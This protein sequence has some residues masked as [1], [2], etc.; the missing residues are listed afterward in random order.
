[1]GTSV[2]KA[3]ELSTAG[4]RSPVQSL[5]QALRG[6][7]PPYTLSPAGPCDTL[8]T[9]HLQAASLANMTMVSPA[10]IRFAGVT[11]PDRKMPLSN[12]HKV[13]YVQ[14]PKSA[15]TRAQKPTGAAECLG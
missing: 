12:S 3:K 8:V 1:M 6:P 9:S 5:P 7:P 11:W 13:V 15:L 14:E 2:R 4:I 10:V